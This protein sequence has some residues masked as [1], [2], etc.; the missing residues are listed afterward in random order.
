ML[1]NIRDWSFG[2]KRATRQGE[3]RGLVRKGCRKHIWCI[4]LAER[5]GTDRE[6]RTTAGSPRVT[7][8][9]MQLSFSVYGVGTRVFSMP[10]LVMFSTLIYQ[11]CSIFK[12]HPATCFKRPLIIYNSRHVVNMCKNLLHC[13]VWETLAKQKT[14]PVVY[15]LSCFWARIAWVSGRKTCGYKGTVLTET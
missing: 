7:H 1:I 12:T 6:G 13:T 15:R 8:S 2:T 3:G 5:K 9:G 11:Y 4:S 10:T 14:G